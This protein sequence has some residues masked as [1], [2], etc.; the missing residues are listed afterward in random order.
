[1][2]VADL[3]LLGREGGLPAS[4]RQNKAVESPGIDDVPGLRLT[5]MTVN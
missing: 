5:E 1:M 3:R 2:I 4:Q